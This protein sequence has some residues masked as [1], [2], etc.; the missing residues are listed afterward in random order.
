MKNNR[1]HDVRH[2]ITLTFLYACETIAQ[3][4]GERRKGLQYSVAGLY[5]VL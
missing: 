1:Q 5:T 2:T 4:M 3:G